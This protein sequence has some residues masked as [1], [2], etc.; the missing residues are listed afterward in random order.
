MSFAAPLVLVALVAIPLLV[1]WYVRRQR[2]RAAAAASF[3]SAPMIPSVA[4]RSPRW[5]RHLPMLAFGIAVVVLIIAGARP[6][7]SVAVPV[8]NG[9]VMLANDVSSSM[10]STDVAPSRLVAAESAAKKFLGRV[11]STARVGLLQFN[12]KPVLLQSPTSDHALVADA[13]SQLH[14]GG[15]TAVGDAITLGMQVLAKQPS[16]NGR[17]PPSAIVLISD[18]NSTNGS[19]PLA[20]ARSARSQHIPVYTVAVGTQHGTIAVKHGSRTVNTPVPEEARQL[21]QIAQLSGG[22]AF[23]AADAGGL[24]AV[25]QHLAAQLGHKQVKKEITAGFAGGGLVLLL[26]GSIMSLRWFGRLV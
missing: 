11:P 14:A 8:N 26:F 5:R 1:I 18:G 7:R 23:T 22:Q 16:Q 12:V 15:H 6:Q 21:A 10:G 25:Y 4:P 24:N 17:R 2:G 19:D 20:V 3:V 9:V 13:L